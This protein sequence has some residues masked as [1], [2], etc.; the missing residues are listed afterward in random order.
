MTLG[1]SQWILSEEEYRALP[2]YKRSSNERDELIISYH[3]TGLVQSIGIRL[4]LPQVTIAT[5]QVFLHRFYIRESF[6][7]FPF[8]E[9]APAL[10]FLTAKVEEHPR[11]LKDVIAASLDAIKADT[12]LATHNYETKEGF[13]EERI[14]CLERIILQT[15]CFDLTVVHPYRFVFRAVKGLAS[16]PDELVQSA[17]IVVNDS[18]RT[19]LCIR[20]PPRTVAVGALCWSAKKKEIDLEALAPEAFASET[21]FECPRKDIDLVLSTFQDLYHSNQSN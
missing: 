15:I 9:L 20:I 3:A 13:S 11:K 2:A 16:V 8:A 12:R 17:W 18:F 5:A 14:L 10:V 1:E 7:T 19:P 6:K 4:K 21:I